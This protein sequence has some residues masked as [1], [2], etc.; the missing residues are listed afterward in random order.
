MPA[1][2][3]VLIISLI[4]V[5]LLDTFGSILSRRFEFSYGRLAII[6]FLIYTVAG[7]VGARVGGQQSGIIVA[8]C[9]GFFDATIGLKISIALR[10]NVKNSLIIA[11]EPSK[12][13]IACVFVT[14]AAAILGF[15]GS[16]LAV[17]LH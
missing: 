3:L 15:V 14:T 10:A 2:Y 12:W 6:S 11:S 8:A 9:T 1:I 16:E 5:V 4:A 7:F 13:I 17:M